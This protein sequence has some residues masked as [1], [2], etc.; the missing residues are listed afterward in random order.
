VCWPLEADQETGHGHPRADRAYQGFA[1]GTAGIALF[2]L[3]SGTTWASPAHLDTAAEAGEALA[4]T[5]RIEE[6][7]PDDAQA[8][9]W[10]EADGRAAGQ[11]VGG[12][13]QGAAGVGS[14]LLA[15]WQVTG[16]ARYRVLAGQAGAAAYRTA[17]H[18]AGG[19][20]HG[21]A[22]IGHFL[23]DLGDALGEPGWRARAGEV[24]GWLAVRAIRGPAGPAFAGSS[25]GTG[26]PGL[27]F[28]D[29][30]AGDLDFALRLQYGGRSPWRPDVVSG[31]SP[32]A[33]GSGARSGEPPR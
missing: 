26:P 23:L 2:L 11:P 19:A 18:A 32:A 22:G 13:C 7:G 1:H 15:L 5:A 24:A 33:A 25:T 9:A 10:W 16:D 12:W 6:P 27:S 4:R 30:M 21:L 14:F 31:R 17:R 29:G 28:A 3:L 20:C 8:A